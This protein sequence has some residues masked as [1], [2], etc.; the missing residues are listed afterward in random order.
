MAFF[1][2]WASIPAGVALGLFA[3]LVGLT[4][5]LSYAAGVL[6]VIVVGEPVRVRLARRLGG[7]AAENPN[8]LIRRAWDRFGLIGLALLAP[9]T[10][11]AQIGAV[12][13]LTLGV[14]ARRLWLA[15]SLG[16]AVWATGL[17]AAIMLGARVV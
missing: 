3:P 16:G 4:A 15:M 5:W 11:G 9:M 17:T 13:G 8:S 14:P 1:Y 12:I 6:L 7:K 2:F 10:T